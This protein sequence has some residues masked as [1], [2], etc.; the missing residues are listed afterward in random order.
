MNVIFMG[1][2]DF[3]VPAFRELINST[4]HNIVALFTQVPKAKG[5]GMKLTNSPVHNLAIENDIPVHTPKTLRN[6]VAVELIKSI[7]VDIIIVV[8][9][10]FIIPENI[11]NAKKYGC[12]N[13]HPSKLPKYRGAAPLQRTIINGEKETAV[14]IMQMDAGLDTGD[15][16]LQE[17]LKL[18][19]NITLPEL[20]D[21]C[22][23]I[24]AKLLIETLDNID[25]LPRKKQS[26]EGLSYAHKLSK[27]EGR[28]NWNESAI[29]ID[30]KIR[31]M[32]PWP[33]VY[34]EHAGKIIKIL[35]SEY[36]ENTHKALPGELLGDNF[37]V[38]CGE[39]TLIIKSLNP[40]GKSKMLATDYLRGLPTSVNK[41]V[42][43]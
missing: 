7:D 4:E 43:S 5:R 18:A 41:V 16:I 28:V 42:F 39:G 3:A 38:A 2:P 30:C 23:N 24:G 14:C 22:A 9:Y 25:S 26:N 12:L 10:G 21:Q 27:E 31:G 37:E 17:Q 20:H 35:S 6:E 19:S 40:A 29:S 36:T 15:I 34:F 8:A 33:G 13:I 1:T 32:N 11:L